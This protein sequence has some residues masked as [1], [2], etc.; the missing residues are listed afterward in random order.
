[1]EVAPIPKP[2][3]TSSKILSIAKFADLMG[4]RPNTPAE[5]LDL[6]EL[7]NKHLAGRL[8]P[9]GGAVLTT[10]IEVT[11]VDFQAA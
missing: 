6:N 7:Y 3:E 11:P 2:E 4:I 5:A 1:M 9:M 10:S 8:Y